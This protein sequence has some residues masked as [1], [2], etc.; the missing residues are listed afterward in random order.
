MAID[1]HDVVIRINEGIRRKSTAAHTSLGCRTTVWAAAK[2]FEI[3]CEECR[4][5]L[6]MK[7]DGL[8][9]N[10]DR[11]WPLFYE[12][13]RDNLVEPARWPMD[14][15]QEC[16][17]F[18]GADPGTG[19]RLVWWLKKKAQPESVSIYGFD[20]WQTVSHWNGKKN[21]PNHNPEL[22]AIAMQKLLS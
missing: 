6:F 7:P 1:A 17:E 10:G 19:I 18:V 9:K 20:F 15:E 2:A 14:M 21:T 3:P 12:W 13:M 4:L 11:D 16:R 22:E 8:T 5:G